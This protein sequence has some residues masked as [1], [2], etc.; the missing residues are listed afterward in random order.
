M[1]ISTLNQKYRARWK[2][3]MQDGNSKRQ[4]EYRDA[5]LKLGTLS[6]ESPEFDAII[7]KVIRLRRDLDCSG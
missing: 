6:P 4:E 1:A 7:T 3:I 2:R 5:L